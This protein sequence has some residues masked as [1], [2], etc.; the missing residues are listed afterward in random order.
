MHKSQ[1]SLN[2]LLNLYSGKEQVLIEPNICK[3]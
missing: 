1:R 3:P 2:N